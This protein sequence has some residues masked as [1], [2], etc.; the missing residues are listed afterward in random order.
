MKLVITIFFILVVS[1][2]IHGERFFRSVNK[3]LENKNDFNVSNYYQHTVNSFSKKSDIHFKLIN[4]VFQDTL[5]KYQT[6][7]F[8]SISEGKNVSSLFEIE[9]NKLTKEFTQA[10]KMSDECFISHTNA[11]GNSC[12]L[13]IWSKDIKSTFEHCYDDKIET[14]DILNC[15]NNNIKINN[16]NETIKKAY[17]DIINDLKKLNETLTLSIDKCYENLQTKF[18]KEIVHQSDMFLLRVISHRVNLKNSS[19]PIN[20]KN[21]KIVSHNLT[22]LY[23]SSIDIINT[24]YV[25]QF[26]ILRSLEWKSIRNYQTVQEVF[27]SIGVN[28]TCCEIYSDK[29]ITNLTQTMLSFNDKYFKNQTS[30]YTNFIN[31]NIQSNTIHLAF[32]DCYKKNSVIE[33]KFKCIHTEILKKKNSMKAVYDMI[34]N[35]M[36]MQ[37][38]YINSTINYFFNKTITEY[39]NKLTQATVPFYEC[40]GYKKESGKCV[41]YYV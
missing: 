2:K 20:E 30:M 41:N 38:N 24:F 36:I 35:D 33:L 34:E 40:V 15:L 26:D 5:D 1:S 13:K 11:F 7:V 37:Y 23:R 3:Q 12:H 18:N 6:F 27:Q 16:K 32:P 31:T 25:R 17:N 9:E 8:S 22:N 39:K 28:I 10:L 4:A 14:N 29:Y 21:I 19:R